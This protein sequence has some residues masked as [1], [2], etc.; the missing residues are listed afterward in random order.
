[1]AQ[2]GGPPL[3]LCFQRVKGLSPSLIVKIAPNMLIVLKHYCNITKV[4]NKTRGI[5]MNK[6]QW[7]R[8]TKVIF[9]SGV[10]GFIVLITAIILSTGT[11]VYSLAIAG[12]NAGY[13]TDKAIIEDA[14]KEITTNYA[15]AP[16]SVDVTVDTKKITY[17]KTDYKKDEVK[18]LTAEALEKKIVDSGLCTAKAWSVSV[19]GKSIAATATKPGAD[20]VLSKVRNHYLD[21]GSKLVSAGFK[22]NVIATQAAVNVTDLMGPDDA[23]NLIITGAKDPRVYI[24]KEGDTIWDIAA[25]NMI[26]TDELQK[27]NPGFDPDKL[28]IGQQLNMY[29]A[30]PFV[31]VVT[32]EQVTTTEIIAFKTVYE[33]TQ[34]L[35]KGVVKVKTPGVNGT[36]AVTSEITKENGTV[37]AANVIDSVVISEPQNQVAMKGTKA[38]T[39]Y[40][41]NRSLSGDMARA[42]AVAAAGS[43]IVSYAKKFLG[44]P[45]VHGGSTP[46]GF[47]CSGFTQYVM[48][49]FGG[50]IPRTTTGQYSSGAKISKSELKPGDLVFFK[51]SA[52]SS[53]IS[54]VGI[55]V[56]SGKFIHAPQPGESVK[57][58]DLSSSYNVSHY[59]GSARV[60]K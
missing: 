33:D 44:V 17:E 11:Q 37:I 47:D 28:Q 4:S 5:V 29:A 13:I 43:D 19:N 41:A 30:K 10:A 8:K 26:G 24:V 21:D 45:Y 36:K 40:A 59:Y 7:N 16:E 2:I 48:G 32:K 58:S 55:Y 1:M 3:S 54:H 53:R 35:N 42:A 60:T 51:P 14:V 12:N 20:E 46:K 22:E 57:I 6:I 39:V 15:K 25:A 49:H 9:L 56:G 23:V 27:A 38:V 18:A 50:S 34:T 31:T 52:G